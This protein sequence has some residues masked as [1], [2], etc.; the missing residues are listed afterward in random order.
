M[1]AEDP[2]V[3]ICRNLCL[4][5]VEGFISLDIVSLIILMIESDFGFQAQQKCCWKVASHG[6]WHDKG[7]FEWDG[8]S[9]SSSTAEVASRGQS[10]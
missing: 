8:G 9:H 1:Y 7:E 5:P 3:L 2:T 4:L 6:R 10:P